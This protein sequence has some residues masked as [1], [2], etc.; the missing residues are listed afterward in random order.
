MFTS[1]DFSKLIAIPNLAKNAFGVS[2][3][4]TKIVNNFTASMPDYSKLFPRMDWMN[5]FDDEVFDDIGEDNIDE[6][7]EDNNGN[8][9]K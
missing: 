2:S 3:I 7:E 4:V 8:D 1:S 5:V 6:N 9:E